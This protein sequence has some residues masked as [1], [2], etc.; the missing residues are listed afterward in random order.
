M[1]H[2]V[3]TNGGSEGYG[4]RNPKTLIQLVITLLLS[5]RPSWLAWLFE[6]GEEEG[7]K[8]NDSQTDSA[9]MNYAVDEF[10]Q[11]IKR[12]LQKL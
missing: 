7:P 5:R 6:R 9:I 2:Y 11:F 8:Q 3:R 10:I 12:G 4:D 1:Y